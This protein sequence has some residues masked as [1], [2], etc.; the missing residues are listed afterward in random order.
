MGNYSDAEVRYK[1]ALIYIQD[2]TPYQYAIRLCGLGEL[3][4]AQDQISESQEIFQQSIIGMKIGEK[5]GE[6]KALAGLSVAA[7][8]MG[9]R[10]KSREIIHQAL[11]KH[12]ESHSHYFTHFSLA[13]YAY[14]LSQQGDPLTGIK[15][16]AMMNEQKFIH[17]SQWF[18]KLYRDPIYASALRDTPDEIHKVE[19]IGKQMNLWKT[20]EQIVLQS[21]K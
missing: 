4:L 11:R 1:Q 16:Y 19:L 18:K 8:K 7:F 17:D 20:L 14:L 15:I 9:E 5:W 2:G 12:H 10:E 21:K 13:A 3:L 6:G